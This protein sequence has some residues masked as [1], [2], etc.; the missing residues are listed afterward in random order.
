MHKKNNFIRYKCLIIA[1]F[2]ALCSPA[3]AKPEASCSFSNFWVNAG[4]GFGS[5][6]K[7]LGI[8]ASYRNGNNVF[9]ARYIY[10]EEFATAD[11]LPC[12]RVW[13]GGLLYGRTAKTCFGMA[14][15]SIGLS[16][17]GGTERINGANGYEGKNFLTFGIPAEYQLFWTPFS[18]A[19]FG[20]YGVGNLNPKKPY[21]GFIFCMQFG[22]LH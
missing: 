17:V 19:G 14:S 1:L 22:Q 15:I 7:S 5:V 18:F 6:G 20:L 11:T 4:Y 12:E 13:D 8:S 3:L 10:N 2:C 9:S 16:V 21:I